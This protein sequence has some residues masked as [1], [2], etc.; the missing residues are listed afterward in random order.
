VTIAGAST[1]D[2]QTSHVCLRHLA[3]GLGAVTNSAD[4][5]FNVGERFDFMPEYEH[6]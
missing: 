5:W 2:K 6:P 4:V 3:E 1:V